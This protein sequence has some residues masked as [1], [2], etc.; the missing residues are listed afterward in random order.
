MREPTHNYCAYYIKKGMVCAKSNNEI[1]YVLKYYVWQKKQQKKTGNRKKKRWH[2][3][4]IVGIQS[5]SGR[6]FPTFGLF[7]GN[8]G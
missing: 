4:K 7:I 8:K 3:V 2:C 1:Y 6:Y 5:Y